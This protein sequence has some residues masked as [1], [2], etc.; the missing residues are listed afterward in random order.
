V[1]TYSLHT[2][3]IH[4]TQDV[5]TT[6]HSGQLLILSIPS[7]PRARP[8]IQTLLKQRNRPNLLA[9]LL[10]AP[11]HGSR[12]NSLRHAVDLCQL[13]TSGIRSRIIRPLPY[14]SYSPP[15]FMYSEAS[16]HSILQS[17]KLLSKRVLADCVPFES[18]NCESSK[19]HKLHIC[20]LTQ[21]ANR[22]SLWAHRCLSF[23]RRR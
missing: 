16:S 18:R 13:E 12:P 7:L 19:M 14:Q 22:L 10:V 17:S 23:C 21:E 20:I 8:R 5:D 2:T 4:Y 9:G 1:Q 3:G 15:G 11:P 6:V